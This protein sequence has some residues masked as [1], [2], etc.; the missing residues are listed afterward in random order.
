V[1]SDTS[2]GKSVKD[3]GSLG[4]QALKELQE[5]ADAN[6][7]DKKKVGPS[8]TPKPLPLSALHPPY[9]HMSVEEYSVTTI[10]VFVA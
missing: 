7:L 10:G 6:E 8:C 9:S 1:K 5:A 3:G 2:F 4:M